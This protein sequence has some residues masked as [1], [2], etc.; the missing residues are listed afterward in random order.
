MYYLN[1]SVARQGKGIEYIFYSDLLEKV[2][3]SDY[4]DIVF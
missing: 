1:Y 3:E 4:L 2:D